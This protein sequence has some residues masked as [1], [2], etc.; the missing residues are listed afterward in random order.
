V[1][2]IK[3][4]AETHELSC[5][6]NPDNQRACFGCKNLNKREKTLY[7][8][9]SIGETSRTFDLCHCSVKDCFLYPPKVEHKGNE[10]DLGY[11]PNEPMPKQCEFYVE[12][13]YSLIG[14]E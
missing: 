13:D 11:E 12:Q 14:A 8:D 6:K 10:L 9:T 7:Y 1:Y 4:F 5:V 2:Q 3:R